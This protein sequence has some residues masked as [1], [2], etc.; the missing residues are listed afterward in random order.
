MRV[1]LLGQYVHVSIVALAAIEAVSFF[2]AL[3]AAAMLRL[4]A[5][6][7]S[8]DPTDG[9]ADALWDC[10]AFFSVATLVS[11]LAFGLYS[12]R[13]RARTAGILVRVAAA[14]A[15]ATVVT[16]ALFYTVPSLR[17]GRGVLA[18]A[19]LFALGGAALSRVLFKGIVDESLFKRRV[20]VYG[21]GQRT[22]AISSLRR[23]SDRRGFEL[24]GFVQ[25]DGEAVAVAPEK[26]LSAPGGLL[27]LCQRH[28]VHEIVVAMED[29]R[30]GFPIF[31]LLDCRLAGVDVTELLTFLERETGRVRIDVMN[32]SWMIFGEGFRRDPMRLFSS[33]ALDLLASFVLLTI[34]LPVM[35]VTMLAIKVEDGW[36]APIFYRQ[37]RVGLGGHPFNVL[38]F[39]SMR[40][41]AE[42][43]GRAQWAQKSDPR[44]T[45]VGNIIRKLRIDELPQILN[46]LRGDMS[47]VGPR[48]ERPQFV[49]ELSEKIP[50]Y[51]QRHCVK[52]GITGWAQLC[53]PYGSSEQDALEKLQYD[54]YYIKNNSLLFD[55]AILVQTAEVVFMGKGAR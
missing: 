30:R 19:S 14:V 50:Y 38:K 4:P 3:L 41:D 27:A 9:V 45:R 53:Y 49:A 54:L 1:R 17:M 18:L 15:A 34:S 23:R 13:Q 42:R 8:G 36:R 48:P 24:I 29:R 31:E 35:L 46:V 12:S 37:A 22:L 2:A 11:L 43:D 44:V 39:R 26:V 32:P 25:P 5:L 55:L 28:E 33:R 47:F 10:A 51:V 52:P 21:A 20:L 16:A 7:A 40:T 6:N